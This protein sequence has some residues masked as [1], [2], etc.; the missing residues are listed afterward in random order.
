MACGNRKPGWF[1]SFQSVQ[2]STDAK[3]LPAASAK[4]PNSFALGRSTPKVSPRALVAKPGTDGLSA[5]ITR[6]PAAWASATAVANAGK[7]G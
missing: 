3:R 1:G 5:S 7:P 6:K 2:R 4:R